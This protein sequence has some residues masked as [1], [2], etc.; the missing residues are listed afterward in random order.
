[1][2]ISQASADDVAE[3][4]RLLWLNHHDEEPAQPSADSFAA[5]LAQ[6]W[7]AHRDSHLAF[8]ARLTRPEIVGMAWVALVPR[9]PRPGATHRLS[10]DL[11]SVYVLPEHRGQGIGAALIE[12]ASAHATHLG[13][14]HVTVHSGHT[15]V[16][17]YERL[18]FAGSRQLLRRE[19]G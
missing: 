19:P 3:L 6:W 4:A 1:V 16:P 14:L 13:S 9:P 5:G 12:A 2:R 17:L 10:A 8:V 11:Q 7:D 18:G 15:A